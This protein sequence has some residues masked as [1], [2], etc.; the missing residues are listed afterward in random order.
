ML[1]MS[2]PNVIFSIVSMPQPHVHY[3]QRLVT[4]NENWARANI[5]NKGWDD[6][7]TDTL[8]VCMVTETIARV[9]KSNPAWGDW[10]VQGKEMNIWVDTSSLAIRFLLEKNGA[11]IEDTC[12]L[13]PMNDAAHINLAELDTVLKG[14]NLVL[15]WGGG[16]KNCICK[17]TPYA[18]TSGCQIP[19]Q[20]KPGCKL[21]QP[22]RCL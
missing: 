2:P 6:E 11:V 8:L 5:V 1:T 13:W 7:T 4:M 12:W 18:C 19:R 17:P 15:Q 21:R 16:L 22:V 10:C 3:H 20:A 14:I 9:K